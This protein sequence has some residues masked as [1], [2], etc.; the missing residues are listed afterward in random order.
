MLT[1][2]LKS[3]AVWIALAIL[4]ALGAYQYQGTQLRAARAD[5]AQARTEQAQSTARAKTAEAEAASRARAATTTQSQATATNERQT[6]TAL[7]G[8][9]RTAD[10][11]RTGR[12]FS[13]AELAD[14]VT[15]HRHLAQRAT[16]AEQR[17]AAAEH[18]LGVL[19]ELLGRA[20]GTAGDLAAY[21]DQLRARLDSCARWAD[22]TA[23]IINAG[24][25]G[26]GVAP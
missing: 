23:S 2:I 15:R 22:H 17:A 3:P 21:A 16:T 25:G 5:L 10:A 4:A 24:P 14:F 20:D 8:I 7:A 6:D 13:S 18:A 12:L 11:E 26:Q 19:A 1:L 9:T